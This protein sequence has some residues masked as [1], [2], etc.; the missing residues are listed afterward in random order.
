MECDP[1]HD[2]QPPCDNN[3]VDASKAVWKALGVLQYQLGGMDIYWSDAG[4]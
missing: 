2:Y 4:D 3:I 1:D